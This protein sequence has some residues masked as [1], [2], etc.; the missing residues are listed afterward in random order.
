ML[1]NILAQNIPS[2]SELEIR[3][4]V[5]LVIDSYSKIYESEAYLEQ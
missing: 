4:F 2:D 1:Q 5:F 3:S